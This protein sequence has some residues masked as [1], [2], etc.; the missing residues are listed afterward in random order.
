MLK[1]LNKIARAVPEAVHLTVSR[2][3]F[4]PRIF[5]RRKY[6]KAANK[7]AS[8]RGKKKRDAVVSRHRS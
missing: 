5:Y 4:L 3:R 2:R 1:T 8:R 7:R 6:G